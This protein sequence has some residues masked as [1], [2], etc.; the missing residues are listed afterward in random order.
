MLS[1]R[2][3]VVST[4]P[5]NCNGPRG[6][7]EY[8]RHL[9]VLRA[10]KRS[11]DRMAMAL[12]RSTATARVSDSSGQMRLPKE[13]H[14]KAHP[15][16]RRT[17]SRF[18]CSFSIVLY[19]FGE[20]ESAKAKYKCQWWCCCLPESQLSFVRVKHRRCRDYVILRT[21]KHVIVLSKLIL[22]SPHSHFLYVILHIAVK[23]PRI[24]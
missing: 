2:L 16:R 3:L 10:R 21:W 9:D 14:R 18:K 1:T 8:Q 24:L 23:L 6:D 17:F 4:Y 15:G 19:N 7:G 20:S 12:M 5:V 11:S 22:P 13:Y